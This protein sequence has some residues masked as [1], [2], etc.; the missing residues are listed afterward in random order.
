MSG[1]TSLM[2][3]LDKVTAERWLAQQYSITLVGGLTRRTYDGTLYPVCAVCGKQV[4]HLETMHT[5]PGIRDSYGHGRQVIFR[6]ACH[7]KFQVSHLSESDR[8]PGIQ[9][10]FGVAFLEEARTLGLVPGEKGEGTVAANA[11]PPRAVLDAQGVEVVD[12]DREAP[13]LPPHEPPPEGG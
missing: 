5:R 7:G 2:D 1:K 11:L 12:S 6:V 8:V 10:G 3:P 9:A 13:V 4:D